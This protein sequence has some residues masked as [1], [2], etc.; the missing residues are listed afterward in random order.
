[1]GRAHSHYILCTDKSRKFPKKRNIC[2]KTVYK[3][4]KGNNNI[5]GEFGHHANHSMSYF[6]EPGLEVKRPTAA[7]SSI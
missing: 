1:M 3:D 6:T 2:R 5:V 4:A 7:R